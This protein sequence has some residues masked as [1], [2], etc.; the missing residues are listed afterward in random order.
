MFSEEVVVPGGI[1]VLFDYSEQRWIVLAPLDQV[2]P[3]QS[4]VYSLSEEEIDLIA[5][6]KGEHAL[7]L[8]VSFNCNSPIPYCVLLNV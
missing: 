5:G 2:K 1:R 8:V 7:S 6:K 4:V 3:E